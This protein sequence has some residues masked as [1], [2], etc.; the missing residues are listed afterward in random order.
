MTYVLIQIA[1]IIQVSELDARIEAMER[2][3]RMRSP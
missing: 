3:L 2:A 1:K